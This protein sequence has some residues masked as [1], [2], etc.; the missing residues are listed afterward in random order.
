MGWMTCHNPVMILV[1]DDKMQSTPVVAGDFNSLGVWERKHIQAWVRQCPTLLGEELLIVAEEFDRFQGS[2]DRLDLLAID[3]EGN[4]VVIEFKRDSHGGYA[5]LQAIRYAAMVSSMSI[6]KLLPYFAAHLRK[7]E[8]EEE[9]NTDEA[10]RRIQTFIGDPTFVELSDRPRIILCS[11]DFSQELTTAVLWLRSFSVDISCVKIVPHQVSGQIVI[12][13]NRIIPI[14]EA[15]SYMIDI[16]EKQESTFAEN[17]QRKKRKQETM[18]YLLDRELLK[19]GDRI[20]LKNDIKHLV[21]DESDPLFHATITGKRGQQ[22]SVIWDKDGMEYSISGLTWRIFQ[23]THPENKD[24][25]GVNGNWHWVNPDGFS[26]WELADL[27]RAS[28]AP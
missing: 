18:T 22:N 14:E 16:R 5:D 2:D 27:D 21:Y 1:V 26:L 28:R 3:K 8:G 17:Q 19:E 6:S 24:P 11:Q 4:L 25:G 23:Q 9:G 13:P 15:Q 7:T 12:V 10:L 20:Y